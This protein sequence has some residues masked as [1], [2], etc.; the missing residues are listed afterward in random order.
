MLTRVLIHDSLSLSQTI[1]FLCKM[2][3]NIGVASGTATLE[4][5][6]MQLRLIHKVG[7]SAAALAQSLIKSPISPNM[8]EVFTHTELLLL[9]HL[10]L[11]PNP[12]VDDQVTPAWR[13]NRQAL[14]ES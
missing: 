1:G 4:L 8:L 14:G 6:L 7:L 3:D 5:E 2:I 13:D 11:I 9:I 10:I 12:L